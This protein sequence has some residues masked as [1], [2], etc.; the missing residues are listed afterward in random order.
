MKAIKIS[1]LC[2]SFFILCCCTKPDLKLPHEE[3]LHSSI[4]IQDSTLP[5]KESLHS[6]ISI[7]LDSVSAGKYFTP[8]LISPNNT[9]FDSVRLWVVIYRNNKLIDYRCLYTRRYFDYTGCPKILIDDNLVERDPSGICTLIHG[10]KKI[11]FSK[12]LPEKVYDL[13]VRFQGFNPDI[14]VFSKI[15]KFNNFV[16]GPE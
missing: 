14:V 9:S 8:E 11:I 12:S 5:L 2:F 1:I 16:T 3:S 7:Q 6:D 4:S 15:V 13:Q 10:N